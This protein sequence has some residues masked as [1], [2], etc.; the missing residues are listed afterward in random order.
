MDLQEA[1]REISLALVNQELLMVIG[2]CSVEYRGRAA[3]RLP[4]GKR[5]CLIKGDHSFGIHQNRKLRPVNYMM[6]AAIASEIREGSLLLSARKAKPKEEIKA[7]FYSVD[8]VHRYALDDPSDLVLVGSERELSGEL[9]KDLSFLEEGL[10][11]VKAEVP[12][13]KGTVDILG[14]DAQGRLVVIEVKRRKAEFD[15]VTQLER[16]MRQ[17]EKMKGRQTR[18]ILVAP[19]IGKA[20]LELLEQYGLEYYRF[21]FDVDQPKARIKGVTKKQPTLREYLSHSK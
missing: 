15:A 17:V 19:D 16:Y 7:H 20:A 10:R 14:E 8:G 1:R 2:D 18:G 4:R 13:R 5:L 9:M 12:L 3:S 21:D 6:G 11:P